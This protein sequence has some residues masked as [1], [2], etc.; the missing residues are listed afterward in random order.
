M[1][2]FLQNL[3]LIFFLP[4]SP[5]HDGGCNYSGR[6]CSC[7]RLFFL[8]LSENLN[9]SKELGTRHR[10]AIGLTEQS[11][12]MAII[13]SEET[14]TISVAE[15]GKLTR[16]L[17]ENMLKDILNKRLLTKQQNLMSWFNWR[18]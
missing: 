9:L 3:S 15:E 18:S 13:V 6:S 11:D 10:A 1:V 12:A 16:Y 8:P 2:W 14:G 7:C 17:D 5:L 4:R